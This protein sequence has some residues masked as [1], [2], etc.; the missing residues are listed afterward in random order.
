AGA[1]A[2]ACVA[3]PEF[4]GSR[5]RRGGRTSAAGLARLLDVPASGRADRAASALGAVEGARDSRA[6]PPAACLAA[7]GCAAAATAGRPGPAGRIE[8]LVAAFGL[9]D[10]LCLAGNAVALASRAGRAALDVLAPQCRSSEDK[11][12]HRRAGAAAGA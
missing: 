1:R 3:R 2:C 4:V 11:P 8:P 9:V 7:S 10:A 5:H 6:P 12:R